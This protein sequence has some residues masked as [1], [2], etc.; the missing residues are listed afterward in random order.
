MVVDR[1][2]RRVEDDGRSVEPWIGWVGVS[3]VIFRTERC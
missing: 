2:D 3:W 1:V